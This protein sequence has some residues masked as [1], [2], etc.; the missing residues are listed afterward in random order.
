MT[1]AYARSQFGAWLDGELDAA[2]RAELEEHVEGCA[3]CAHALDRQRALSEMLR[4]KVER[5]SAPAGLHDWA[6]RAAR[7]EA[8]ARG[9]ASARSRAG[10][11]QRTS[12]WRGSAG[13]RRNVRAPRPRPSVWERLRGF[14][15]GAVTL[16]ALA[17]LITPIANHALDQSALAGDL[18]G[19]H[20]RSLE[21][22]HLIDVVSTDQHTVKPW[23]NG[24]LDFSPP[25]V[26][27]A[28]AGFPLA[29]GRL[30]Y[31]HGRSVAALVFHRRQ[32]PINL[33]VWPATSWSA[34]LP[35]LTSLAGRVTG[36]APITRDG[37]HLER[38]VIGGMECWAISDLNAG[39]LH[40]FVTRFAA[41]VDS[42]SAAAQRR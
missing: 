28:D 40:E 5:V 15:F 7:G 19:G 38:R 23:F 24:R 29:G 3:A 42:S 6:R 13:A 8:T 14:G 4:T 39:E 25:V 34:R 32:H 30:D 17:V 33:Y 20:V 2:T 26:D 16:A 41:R 21:A 18:V 12:D 9:E 37:Y 11:P 10:V 36:G 22:E 31:V 27:L 1:H 35:W